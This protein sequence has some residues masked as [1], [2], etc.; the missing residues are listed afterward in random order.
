MAAL[1]VINVLWRP[2]AN[3]PWWKYNL[4]HLFETNLPII[5]K[6]HEDVYVLYLKEHMR[7]RNI[8]LYIHKDANHSNIQNSNS[9][10][11]SAHKQ[12]DVCVIWWNITALAQSI[13]SGLDH[14]SRLVSCRQRCPP[15]QSPLCH[16]MG[17][18]SM[19][20]PSPA[21]WSSKFWDRP[22]G[23]L[24]ALFH[25]PV[26]LHSLHLPHLQACVPSVLNTI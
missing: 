20:L 3:G 15:I 11:L 16:Q 13:P 2:Y 9:L 12:E 6:S 23:L 1:S 21:W 24:W 4:E 18:M 17:L 26:Q 10:K 5:V 8:Y 19:A 7:E 25:L 22:P 14:C